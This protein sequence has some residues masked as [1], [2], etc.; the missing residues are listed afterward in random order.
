MI[1]LDETILEKCKRQTCN[2]SKFREFY[3]FRDVNLKFDKRLTLKAS[4]SQN[5]DDQEESKM[6]GLCQ[7]QEINNTSIK[8]IL[9]Q[10]I[11]RPD[12]ERPKQPS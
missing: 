1:N 8:W 11:Y 3:L 6:C 10:D 9:P 2:F 4:A 7:Q 12:S 5:E